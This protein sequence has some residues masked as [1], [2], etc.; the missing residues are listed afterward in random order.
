MFSPLRETEEDRIYQELHFPQVQ[1]DE[2]VAPDN[3]DPM[4][5]ESDRTMSNG[6]GEYQEVDENAGYSVFCGAAGETEG[7]NNAGAIEENIYDNI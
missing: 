5:V 6:G 4:Y 2:Y 3:M 7:R 1:D